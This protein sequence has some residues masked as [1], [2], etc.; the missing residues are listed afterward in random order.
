MLKNTFLVTICLILSSVFGF[1]SQIVFVQSFGASGEMDI[2]FSLLSVPMVVTG[3]SPMIFSSVLIPTFAKFRTA[4]KELY[5]FINSTW[6][7]IFIF[8]I[9]FTIIGSIFSI[10]NIEFFVSENESHRH[11]S[12]IQAALMIWIG[13]GFSIMSSYLS[14]ILNYNKQFF[15][16]AWT[17]LLPA[18]FMI[19]IVLIFHQELGIRSITLGFCTAFILQFIIFFK[20]TDISINFLKFNIYEIKF[21]NLLIKQTFFVILSLLPFTLLVPIS[22]FLASDLEPGSISYLGYSQSFAGFLSVATSMGISIVSFP[23]LADKLANN[24]GYYDLIKFEKSLRY[25]ILIAMFAA[26]ALISLRLPVLSLF[27]ERG[28]FTKESV[29]NLSKVVPWYLVAAVFIG[30]LNLL[31]TFFYSKGE[32]KIIAKLGIIFPII[33]YIVATILKYDYSYV[34]IGIAYS[35]TF[36]A[37]FFMTVCFAKKKNTNFLSIKFLRFFIFNSSAVLVSC[38]TV[39]YI[40]TYWHYIAS[41]SPVIII[42]VMSFIYFLEY[43]LIGKYIFKFVEIDELLLLLFSKSKYF[44][45]D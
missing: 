31:R 33:F 21:K 26:G 39:Y 23:E 29:F 16:V 10:Y 27:Y 24:K 40:L 17:S 20:S 22:F 12:S 37:L 41:Q 28:S 2:Y 6:K 8:A 38:F 14:A 34:G 45:R 5:I 36:G 42:I 18:T 32:F 15:K 9:L 13:S 19:T 11:N 4:S 1:A 30:G 35:L 3:I 7:I 44:Y 43:L 25:V